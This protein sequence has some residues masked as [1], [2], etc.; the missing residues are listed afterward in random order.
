M[1]SSWC[2]RSVRAVLFARSAIMRC[3]VLLIGVCTP[4]DQVT[5]TRGGN[6]VHEFTVADETGAITLSLWNE[7]GDALSL[8]DIVL[9][10]GGYVT[11]QLGALPPAPSRATNVPVAGAP[12]FSTMSWCS[13][14]ATAA[15]RLWG[16]SAWCLLRL[17]TC[18]A[19]SGASMTRTTH[20]PLYVPATRA[21]LCESSRAH[22]SHLVQVPVH[23]PQTVSPKVSRR[24]APPAPPST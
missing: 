2:W 15:S 4:T 12:R 19:S 17:P 10:S 22:P 9:L 11:S 8:G 24:Q 18:H 16:I 20:K 7:K 21:S 14:L 3:V 6:A 5:S 13:T 1:Q 23:M